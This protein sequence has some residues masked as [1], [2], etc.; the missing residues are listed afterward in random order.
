MSDNPSLETLESKLERLIEEWKKAQV[1]TEKWDGI[2]AF[3]D[4]PLPLEKADRN[5]AE[6]VALHPELLNPVIPPPYYTP[7]GLE[8]ALIPQLL[9]L[10]DEIR[11][12]QESF[13]S[14]DLEY[15]EWISR[16]S[17]DALQDEEIARF[18]DKDGNLRLPANDRER[19]MAITY[20]LTHNEMMV[21]A[22]LKRADALR[23]LTQAKNRLECARLIIQMISRGNGK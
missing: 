11:R 3:R 17:I 6:F 16:G 5:L 12:L 10:P 1:S 18:T 21:N 20:H 22:T 14:A 2:S 15:Q 13:D 7:D 9:A 4:E 23:A 19:D 8:G